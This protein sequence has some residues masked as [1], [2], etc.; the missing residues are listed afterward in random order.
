MLKSSTLAYTKSVTY[1]MISGET[2]VLKYEQN[3]RYV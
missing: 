3:A 1:C 2:G